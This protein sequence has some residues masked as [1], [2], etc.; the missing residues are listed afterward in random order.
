M[1]KITAC[2]VLVILM[3]QGCVTSSTTELVESEES[4]KTYLKYSQ[5]QL[6]SSHGLDFVLKVPRN[7]SVKP[8][9]NYEANFNNHPFYVSFAALMSRDTLLAVHAETVEDES[10]YL[11]Y[12]HLERFDI[13]NIVFY[14]KDQCVSLDE[15]TISSMNDLSYVKK[16]GFDFGRPT[17]LA[18]FFKHADDGNKEIVLTIARHVADCSDTKGKRMEFTKSVERLIDIRKSE[19]KPR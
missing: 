19:N 3:I 11:N 14:R 12:G 18:Q 9:I 17:Y 8:I 15:E 6:T 10:G 16:E 1:F 13:D 5:A 7:F 2:V 4:E